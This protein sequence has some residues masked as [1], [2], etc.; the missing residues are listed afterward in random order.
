[1]LRHIARTVV[2]TS[3]VVATR[4]GSAASMWG[5]VAVQNKTDGI[6]VLVTIPQQMFSFPAELAELI[7]MLAQADADKVDRV[8]DKILE[9]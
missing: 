3:T 8:L 2:T 4:V 5:V 9:E 6:K 7:D 1:M